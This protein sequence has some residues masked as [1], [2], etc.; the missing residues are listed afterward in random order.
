MCTGSNFFRIQDPSQSKERYKNITSILATKFPHH[1]S[2]KAEHIKDGL[3][4]SLQLIIFRR[5]IFP[6]QAR[7][8]KTAQVP[9]S[10][11]LIGDSN[12]PVRSA[13]LHPQQKLK[14]T[15]ER[16]ILLE[17]KRE[18]PKVSLESITFENNVAD[19][20]HVSDGFM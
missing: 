20:R 10:G 1:L 16:E 13:I 12:G 5:R 19:L 4:C 3:I 9:L 11:P 8:I 18:M 6:P 7:A 14:L 15:R 17:N 2:L